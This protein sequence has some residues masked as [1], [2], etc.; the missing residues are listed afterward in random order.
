MVRR[1]ILETF[2]PKDVV[3]KA[4]KTNGAAP[5]VQ[6]R[7]SIAV[8]AV[9]RA[10]ASI[11]LVGT[12][13]LIVHQFSEKAKTMMRDKQTGVART[14][15]QAKVPFNEFVGSLY[16]MPGKALPSKTLKVGGAWKFVANTFYVPAS[17]LKNALVTAAPLTDLAKTQIRA[18]IFIK[19]DRIPLKYERLVMREDMVKIGKFPNKVADIRY[20]GEFQGWSLVADVE[21]RTDVLSAPELYNL[22]DH[23]GFSIGLHEWRP[24]KNGSFGRFEVEKT[25]GGEVR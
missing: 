17:G 14:A 5:K 15:K 10:T 23:A 18:G 12:S 1:A 13:P 2:P 25:K 16:V 7:G 6:P 9:P 4:P 24:E 22:F 19:Q 21:F 8:I 20:R 3:T 11:H